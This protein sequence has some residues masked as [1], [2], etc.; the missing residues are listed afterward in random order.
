MWVSPRLRPPSCFTPQHPGPILTI[1]LN[2]SRALLLS[3]PPSPLLF[4]VRSVGMFIFMV[5]WGHSALVCACASKHVACYWM[6]FVSSTVSCK[7]H[8]KCLT[9]LRAHIPHWGEGQCRR[10]LRWSSSQC[11]L[12]DCW[13][14]APVPLVQNASY[15][16]HEPPMSL[17]RFP[18]NGEMGMW[19]EGVIRWF[20]DDRANWDCMAEFECSYKCSYWAYRNAQTA[21]GL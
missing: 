13:C 17:C 11:S 2:E 14:G 16:E 12:W 3:V 21:W 6:R 4:W 1:F 20:V 18:Q 9:V 8:W 5:G 7:H 19:V 10:I 15:E